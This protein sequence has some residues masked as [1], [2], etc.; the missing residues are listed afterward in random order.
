[1]NHQAQRQVIK[2]LDLEKRNK[3]G[4]SHRERLRVN[5]FNNS[6]ISQFSDTVQTSVTVDPGAVFNPQHVSSHEAVPYKN[7]K[8][9]GDVLAS[10]S[11]DNQSTQAGHST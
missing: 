7:Q 10:G 11:I 8:S 4:Y 2:Q 9:F 3:G 5:P 6:K 1:L